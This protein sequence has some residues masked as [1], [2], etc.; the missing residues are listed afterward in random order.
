MPAATLPKLPLRAYDCSSRN[1]AHVI[2]HKLLHNP[3][4]IAHVQFKLSAYKLIN[5]TLRSLKERLS[6]E[7]RVK[8]KGEWVSVPY[9]KAQAQAC[10]QVLKLMGFGANGK[11]PPLPTKPWDEKT[12]RSIRYAVEHGDFPTRGQMK[13]F[14]SS[15]LAKRQTRVKTQPE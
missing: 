8:V 6:T 11:V 15:L 12:Y 2:A 4:V 9:Y 5:E 1:S 13:D 3:K 14:K 7:K 10:D